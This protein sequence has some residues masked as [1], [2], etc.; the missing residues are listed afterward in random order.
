VFDQT[1]IMVYISN[2]FVMIYFQ[3]S[4]FK[5]LLFSGYTY[6][7]LSIPPTMISVTF[8]NMYLKTIQK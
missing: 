7:L 4:R 1:K 5:K 6:L 8:N 3:S 2:V